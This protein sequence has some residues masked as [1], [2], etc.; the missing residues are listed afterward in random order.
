MLVRMQ[1]KRS[2][3]S[4]LV[5][6]GTAAASMEI[7]GKAFQTVKIGTAKVAQV[8]RQVNT[9]LQTQEQSSVPRIHIL[10]MSTMVVCACNLSARDRWISGACWLAIMA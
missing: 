5:R 7:S 2:P 3:H 4:L 8:A 10:K 6:V 1:T 9:S